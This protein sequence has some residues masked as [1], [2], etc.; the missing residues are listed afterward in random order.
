[1]DAFVI[2]GFYACMREQFTKPGT[3]IYY[4]Q[5]EWNIC[6]NFSAFLDGLA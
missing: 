1:M 2:N 5:V 6:G 4:Q 3:A